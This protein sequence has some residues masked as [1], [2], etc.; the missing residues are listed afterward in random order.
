MCNA[1]SSPCQRRIRR[2]PCS[3]HCPDD[4]HKR[5]ERTLLKPLPS[6]RSIAGGMR[7]RSP[8]RRHRA[9]PPR[10]A[11][12]GVGV[13]EIRSV[14]VE[15]IEDREDAHRGRIHAGGEEASEEAWRKQTTP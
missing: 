9:D 5:R 3:R 1:A 4:D 11:P 14:E 2:P 6:L 13:R 8:R 15:K 12:L 7:P 10:S